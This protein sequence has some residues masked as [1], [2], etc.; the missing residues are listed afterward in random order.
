[1]AVIQDEALIQD[2][3]VI[4]DEALIQDEAVIQDG[5]VKN[6]VVQEEI[7]NP[8][9]NNNFEEMKNNNQENE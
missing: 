1:E 6:Q 5:A 4:Q 8:E 2:E 3:A 9:L 7:I